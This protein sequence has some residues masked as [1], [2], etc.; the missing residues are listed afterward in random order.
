VHIQPTR[1]T[2]MKPNERSWRRLIG[3]ELDTLCA[4]K[5]FASSIWGRDLE[6]EWA[7][8]LGRDDVLVVNGGGRATLGGTLKEGQR[9]ERL[10]NWV[11]ARLDNW[12]RV[13]KLVLCIDGRSR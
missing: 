5:R 13:E 6:G 12:D 8:P 3:F 1:T 2:A 10:V 9:G 4:R 7:L 11:D